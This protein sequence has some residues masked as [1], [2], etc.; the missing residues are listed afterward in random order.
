MRRISF[1]LAILLLFLL[2]SIIIFSKPKEINSPEELKKFQPNQKILVQGNVVK[3]ITNIDKR[4]VYL[5]NTLILECPL[6]CPSLNNK[7]I[8]AICTLNKYNNKNYLKIL[9]LS[10]PG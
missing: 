5:N 8:S 2:F 3:E 10:M 6:P 7:D 4:T 1:I 9:K